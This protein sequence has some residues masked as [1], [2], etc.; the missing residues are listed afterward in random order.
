LDD[1]GKFFNKSLSLKDFRVRIKPPFKTLCQNKINYFEYE[2]IIAI[3]NNNKGRIIN[4][5]MVIDLKITEEKDG[6]TIDFPLRYVEIILDNLQLQYLNTILEM[7]LYA[8]PKLKSNIQK[9]LESNRKNQSYLMKKLSNVHFNFSLE[10]LNLVLLYAF[11]EKSHKIWLS[12]RSQPIYSLELIKD[13]FCFYNVNFYLLNI[14]NIQFTSRLNPLKNTFSLK[15]D[16]IFFN[17]INSISHKPKEEKTEFCSIADEEEFNEEKTEEEKIQLYIQEQMN[18]TEYEYYSYNIIQFDGKLMD[19]NSFHLSWENEIFLETQN[20]E[21]KQ[22][23]IIRGISSPIKLNFHPILF[24]FIKTINND[25]FV[26]LRNMLNDLIIL[27]SDLKNI[28]SLLNSQEYLNQNEDD[29]IDENKQKNTSEVIFEFEGIN[30]E[31]FNFPHFDEFIN[32]FSNDHIFGLQPYLFKKLKDEN[33][34][35][36]FENTNSF[37]LSLKEVIILKNNYSNIS[38]SSKNTT[39]SFCKD[40]KK[41]EILSICSPNSFDKDFPIKV[42][43]GQK[44]YPKF[45]NK[46]I[47][48][49]KLDRI[50]KELESILTV[51]EKF[52]VKKLTVDTNHVKMNVFLENFMQIIN[53]FDDFMYYFT[54]KDIFQIIYKMNIIITKMYRSFN[55]LPYL[56][57]QEENSCGIF[58]SFIAIKKLY[59]NI[60]SLSENSEFMKWVVDNI[61]INFSKIEIIKFINLKINNLSIY[62]PHENPQN[63]HYL[64]HKPSYNDENMV[65]VCMKIIEMKKNCI[66]SPENESYFE[67]TCVRN[68]NREKY[69]YYLKEKFIYQNLSNFIEDNVILLNDNEIYLN[70]ELKNFHLSPF[71][72]H[73]HN[74]VYF[75]KIIRLLNSYS[76]VKASRYLICTPNKVISYY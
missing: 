43:F 24:F 48:D 63:I 45:D 36:Y 66:V 1:S 2:N 20:N 52:S 9:N 58:S 67:A 15:F 28:E 74:Y 41:Y 49:C 46:L 18:K 70:C 75:L 44:F 13:I 42:D 76:V 55:N 53:F 3:T 25:N 12:K 47:K 39:L 32:F 34:K 61:N 23:S 57:K 19:K 14:Q 7:I 21:V 22:T 64:L 10:V 60:C 16:E 65:E 71:T 26:S 37:I 27:K 29:E 5:E 35:K 73:S 50:S 33:F 31:L 40:L 62:L 11:I 8:D 54:F 72:L 56:I 51:K 69:G 4:E 38:I 17:Y 30:I 68:I 6:I 59:I